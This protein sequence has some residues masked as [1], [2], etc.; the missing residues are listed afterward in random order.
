MK[1]STALTLLLYVLFPLAGR[2]MV[3]VDDSSNRILYKGNWTAVQ[4]GRA[5]GSSN[6][7]ASGLLAYNSTVHQTQDATA[8]VTFEFEGT[9]ISVYGLSNPEGDLSMT[10]SIDGAPGMK[11]SGVTLP[12]DGVPT[13]KLWFHMENLPDGSH[14][15]TMRMHGMPWNGAYFILDFLIYD[16]TASKFTKREPQ[17]PFQ[18]DPTATV[19]DSLSIIAVTQVSSISVP[20]SDFTTSTLTLSEPVT[21]SRSLSLESK[22]ST[23]TQALTDQTKTPTSTTTRKLESASI[24]ETLTE[25]SSPT[26]SSTPSQLSP[27]NTDSTPVPMGAIIGAIVGGLLVIIVLLLV[28]Y[29]LTKKR[30]PLS[31]HGDLIQ[32]FLPVRGGLSPVRR[33]HIDFEINMSGQTQPVSAAGHEQDLSTGPI[34]PPYFR[35]SFTG[36]PKSGLNTTRESAS[37]SLLQERI[38]RLEREIADMHTLYASFQGQNNDTDDG[39]HRASTL[40]P[41]YLR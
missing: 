28:C 19:P 27:S 23:P 10:Y 1:V 32:P 11:Q 31:M 36:L 3:L 38:G 35:S 30:S 39:S 33:P 41:P 24:S 9:V 12:G 5:I 17:I 20:P 40:P 4:P 26:V 13:R 15:L 25:L 22:F 29:R 7:P 18:Q 34:Y 14:N 8:E 6:Y 2:A 16:P 37:A 21:L